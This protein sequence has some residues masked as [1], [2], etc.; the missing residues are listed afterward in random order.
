MLGG[1]CVL[2]GCVCGRDVCGGMCAGGDVCW[3]GGGKGNHTQP[4]AKPYMYILCLPHLIA[5]KSV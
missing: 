1:M 2:G 3:G 5:M 4:V